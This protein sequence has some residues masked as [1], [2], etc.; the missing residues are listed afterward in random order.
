MWSTSNMEK[1]QAT[2]NAACLRCA[3]HQGAGQPFPASR[4]LALAAVLL[5]VGWLLETRGWPVPGRAALVASLSLSGWPVVVRGIREMARASLGIE[6]LVT[7]AAAAAP[8]LGEWVEAALV[9]LLF[10]VGEG[11]EEAVSERNRRSLEALLHSAPRLARVRREG[12]EV[13]VPAESLQPGD[14]FLL[15]PGDRAPAD[16]RVVEGSSALDES[17]I[18][19]EAFPVGKGVGDTVYAGSINREGF[20]EVVVT[21]PARE[22]TLARIIRLVE[23]AQETRAPSHRL[24]DRFARYYTPAIMVA[25]AIMALAPLLTGAPG[26]PWVYRALALLLVACPCALVISTPTAIV[27]AIS[28]AARRGILIK[29]GAYLEVLG[30]LRALAFDKTG[31]LTLGS[32]RLVGVLTTPGYREDDILALAAAVESFSEH[33]VARAL[34]REA[35]RQ[36]I[37]APRGEDFRAF[38]GL[39]ARARVAGR[40]CLVGSIRLFAGWKIPDELARQAACHQAD[41]HTMVLVGCDGRVVGALAVAD[42]MRPG[43][44]EATARLKEMGLGHLAMLTGDHLA[45]ARAVARQLNLDSVHHGLLPEEKVEAVKTLRARYGQVGMVGDGVNDAAALAAASL[46]VAMGAAGS[47]AALEAADVALM[48]DD[49]GTLP[50]A[51]SLGRRTLRVIAQNV[52]LA[53]GAKLLALALLALGRLDLWMAVLSDSGA[54]VLVTLNSMR[55]LRLDRRRPACVK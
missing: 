54:A 36:G 10:A 49:L 3:C 14:I 37:A 40:E 19:G 47:E 5:L 21:H 38:P 8:F 44:R 13:E 25:A 11:L 24:V 30:R 2:Q 23:E 51:V 27:A 35:A 55:L 26:R 53:V 1:R 7:V 45:P 43:A 41:G 20:L 33:P 12:K 31:T 42:T 4:R 22:T 34:V 9:M 28:A 15:R 48:G 32:P 50:E 16:G 52:M 6:A 29:G 17:P 39:G 46:G 18:T